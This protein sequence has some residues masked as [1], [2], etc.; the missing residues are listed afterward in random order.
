MKRFL[1]LTIILLFLISPVAVFGHTPLNTGDGNSTPETAIFIED[2]TKSWTL[3]QELDEVDYY[4]IHLHMGEEL[5]V[6]LYVSIWGDEHFTPSLVVMGPDILGGYEPIFEHPEELGRVNV[7][8]ERPDHP[9]YEPFTPASYYYV[10]SY[11]HIVSEDGDYYI[12]VSSD[13]HGGKYGMA[14]GYRETFT[15][16]EWLNI[17]IDLVRIHLW[18][19][20]PLLLLFG[21]PVTSLILCLYY[22]FIKNP[23]QDM[24]LIIGRLSGA[25]YIS[26]GVM[27]LSQMIVYQLAAGFSGSVL[28]TLF[29]VVAQFGLGYAG[30]RG[31]D[32]S[33]IAWIGLSI[34]G[35]LS[36]AGWIIGP[37][38]A[39]IA[40]II[41]FSSRIGILNKYSYEDQD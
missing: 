3:Y 6:S 11:S 14:L 38:L 39:L 2:P 34:G 9:E 15:L 22:L 18:E 26:S 35:F 36:W 32:K 17:P 37:V 20:E 19:E 24:S 31:F 21:P 7:P 28:L 25:L 1:R 30:I 29:F 23:V 27:T 4:K 16:V 5:R 13:S 40:G 41:Q 33:W 12:A 8:G 10:A